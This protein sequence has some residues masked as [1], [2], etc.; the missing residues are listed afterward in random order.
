MGYR[1]HPPCWSNWRIVILC[2]VVTS[3]GV[4]SCVHMQLTPFEHNGEWARKPAYKRFNRLV[5]IVCVDRRRTNSHDPVA[6]AD[7]LLLA[8]PRFPPPV[9]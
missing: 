7:A 2:V 3:T 1:L 6:L 8:L 9:P 4:R 5:T